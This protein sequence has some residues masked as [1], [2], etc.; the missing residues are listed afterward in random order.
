M[1]SD[2]ELQ[3]IAF[4]PDGKPNGRAIDPVYRGCVEPIAIR[5]GIHVAGAAF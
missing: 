1:A 3:R 2:E 4:P 5:H